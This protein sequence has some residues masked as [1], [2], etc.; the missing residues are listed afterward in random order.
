MQQLDSLYSRFA[1]CLRKMQPKV[2]QHCLCLTASTF[3][4]FCFVLWFLESKSTIMNMR[5]KDMYKILTQTQKFLDCWLTDITDE[6]EMS[7]FTSVSYFTRRYPTTLQSS[8]V[9]LL[10][11]ER[12]NSVVVFDSSENELNTINENYPPSEK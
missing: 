8:K 11:N 7:P 2:F 6:Y 12:E 4:L 1:K 5:R 9:A 10:E 3:T